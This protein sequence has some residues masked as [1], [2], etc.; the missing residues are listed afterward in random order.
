MDFPFRNSAV[1]LLL[2]HQTGIRR[3]LPLFNHLPLLNPDS[4]SSAEHL[5]SLERRPNFPVSYNIAA[6]HL[7]NFLVYSQENSP[8]FGAKA[9]KLSWKSGQTKLPFAHRATAPPGQDDVCPTTRRVAP[10][11]ASLEGPSTQH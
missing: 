2:L 8:L 7:C 9:A 5:L 6:K 3:T 4:F 11:G 10:A 1:Q